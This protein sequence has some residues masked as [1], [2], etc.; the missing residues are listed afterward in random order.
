MLR[1]T[2]REASQVW[3]EEPA[4]FSCTG[5]LAGKG[6]VSPIHLLSWHRN[7]TM[8]TAP[9]GE[10]AMGWPRL[11]FQT[12][13]A[14]MP[15]LSS[16]PMSASAPPA[17]DGW[18][19]FPAQRCLQLDLT[20]MLANNPHP[21]TSPLPSQGFRMHMD[22]RISFKNILGISQGSVDSN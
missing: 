11:M 6:Q 20:S 3:Q 15:L 12:G 1:R 9:A 18:I 17:L 7:S 13:L 16:V 4:C 2:G 5:C 21:C 19:H 8:P 22:L 10:K 14:G